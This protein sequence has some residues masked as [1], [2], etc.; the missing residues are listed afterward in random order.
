MLSVLPGQVKKA[1]ERPPSAQEARP[2]G[3]SLRIRQCIP[4]AVQASNKRAGKRW[5]K[6]VQE[7][8][9]ASEQRQTKPGEPEQWQE[10]L[11]L[12]AAEYAK[13]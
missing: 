7:R 9:S 13:G 11:G 2:A 8:F 4:I 10:Q 5:T 1:Y 3:Q 12:E 6:I